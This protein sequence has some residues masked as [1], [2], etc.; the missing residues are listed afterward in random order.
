[1]TLHEILDSKQPV[2]I[3]FFSS[4]C[5]PCLVLKETLNKVKAKMGDNCEIYTIDKQKHSNV[6]KAFGVKSIP[7]LKLF[8][9]A[10]L[11]WEGSG[12]YD[13]NEL[14]SLITQV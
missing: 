3:D 8:K 5:P 12:I 9:N 13:E 6:F 14:I 1:M 10:K 11:V 4:D 7:H 2:L